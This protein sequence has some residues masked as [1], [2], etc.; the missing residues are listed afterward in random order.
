MSPTRRRLL[1]ASAGGIT[2]V[3]G[4]S[5]L[6]DPQQSLLIA[7]NNYTESRHAGRLL[8]END[9]TAVARQ[10]VEVAAAEPDEWATVETEIALGEL[11]SGTRLDVT[12]TFGDGMETNDSIG[13]DCRPEYS[14]DA[15]YV[16]IEKP[17]DLRLNV[18]CYDEFPSK[19]ASQG[20]IDHS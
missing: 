20:G 1:L 3:S 18:A 16:Q 10:Y 11:P 8:I 14:G 5:S 13:L 2:A 19:E 9:G 7:V 15:V 4:C 12:A 6:S 17:L